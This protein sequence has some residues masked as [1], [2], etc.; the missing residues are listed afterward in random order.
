MSDAA[1]LIEDHEFVVDLARYAEGSLTEQQVKKKYRFD[2]E[3]W[4]RLGED[5]TLVE[6]IENEK[7][8][9]VRDGSAARERAQQ[10]FAKAPGVLGDI[11]NDDGASPRHR[12][13]SAKELRQIATPPSDAGPA[14]DRFV[15]TINLGGDVV[16]HYNKSIAIDANDV[17]PNDSNDTPQGL[18]AII[19]ANKPTDDGNGNPI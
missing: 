7:I 8:R 3:T 6:R 19:A 2:D 12:I 9:R 17:D 13:E 5:A 10:I 14:L 18:V 11:L 1:N 15:I 16:E 4:L